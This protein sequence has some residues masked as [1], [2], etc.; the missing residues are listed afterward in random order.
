MVRPLFTAQVFAVRFCA[1]KHRRLPFWLSCFSTA[2]SDPCHVLCHSSKRRN[3]LFL[4]SSRASI[5][6]PSVPDSVS[7]VANL[8]IAAVGV[9]MLA[10]PRAVAQGGWIGAGVLMLVAWT[11]AAAT[12]MMQVHQRQS[13]MGERML[14]F[15]YWLCGCVV[16]GVVEAGGRERET[17]RD[18]DRDREGRRRLG[19]SLTDEHSSPRTGADSR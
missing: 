4:P 11:V 6:M 2:H 13:L 1:F 7:S 18:R 19:V 14:R 9:G 3:R 10:L 5:I 12:A 17:D 15:C 8:V 16:Y